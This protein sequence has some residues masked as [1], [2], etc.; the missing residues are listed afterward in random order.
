MVNKHNEPLKIKQEFKS[1]IRPLHHRDY[2]ALEQN[3]KQNGC[4]EPIITWRGY[5][6]DGHNRYEIC[7]KNNIRYSTQD[8]NF[9]S[10]A[11]AIVWLCTNQLQR[12]DI[13]FETRKYL[14]GTLYEYE[15][16]LELQRKHIQREFAAS[17]DDLT[18]SDIDEM[19]RGVISGHRTAEK[20]AQ[21]Y[22][23]S[24]GT[25][26]KYA[27]FARSLKIVE[28][29]EP[30]LVHKI[31]SGR[32]RVS[33]KNFVSLAKLSASELKDINKRLDRGINPVLN[34]RSTRTILSEPLSNQNGATVKD[35]PS[36]DPDAQ[37]TALTLTVPSWVSSIQRAKNNTDFTMVSDF[38]AKNLCFAL[39][40]LIDTTNEILDIIEED[41]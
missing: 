39:N 10:E 1:L 30:A 34:Y 2:E 15:K 25:V 4:R 36:Y 3:I 9:P 37:I 12:H 26:Q 17:D 38:A 33:H 27:A 40:S 31:L 23:V 20:I 14:I 5:I 28:L 21:K 7:R 41:E 29:K 32:Y 6:L 18:P 35:M 11:D 24:Y 13:A 8:M 19:S 16:V 22:N